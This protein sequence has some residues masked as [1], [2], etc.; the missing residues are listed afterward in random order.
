MAL[1]TFDWQQPPPPSCRGGAVT[2]GN[3]DGVH[4]GH[5][6][7]V[8]ET[9]RLASELSGP[10]VVL[11]FDP[12]PLQLLRP[13]RFLPLLTTLDDRA[14]ILHERGADEV[15]V[16]KTTPELLQLP[17]D[18]FFR[19]VLHDRF[20]V[21]ALVEGEDFRFGH[22]RAGD[23]SLLRVLC[24]SA[25]VTLAVLPPVTLDGTPVSSS[26]VRTALERGDVAAA[27]RLLARPYRLHGRVG[28][29]QKRGRTLGF[30]TANLELLLNFAPGGGVY[31]VRVPRAERAWPGAA[32]I[33]P[34][35]TFGEQGRK[36]EVH[37]IGF[38]GDLYG[39]DLAVDFLAR[40]RDTRPFSDVDELRE[41]LRRDVEQASA[42][43]AEAV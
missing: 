31:A 8:V 32:N 36:V 6:S 3:F 1:H 37:L 13:E 33:G 19:R 9:R 15:V 7:L 30:P 26:R 38:D 34:N 18:E 12:H 2:I 5:T 14:A 29:G 35:P 20:E 27:A 24:Q 22:R 16:L 4:R 25:G 11:T 17:P 42:L 43:A 40:L 21:R 39:E 10:A 41:Q 28:T 23:V